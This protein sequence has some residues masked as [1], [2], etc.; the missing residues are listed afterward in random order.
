MGDFHQIFEIIVQYFELKFYF[1]IPAINVLVRALY[2][3][4]CVNFS[5]T[6]MD[7]RPSH[8][9]DRLLSLRS[10]DGPLDTRA[11]LPGR[12]FGPP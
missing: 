4:C 10:Y 2:W 8:L 7:I 9:A 12:R 1:T 3:V 6:S 5:S 11:S